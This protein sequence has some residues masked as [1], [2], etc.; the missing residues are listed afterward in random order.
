MSQAP[1]DMAQHPGLGIHIRMVPGKQVCRTLLKEEAVEVKGELCPL[2][3]PE[4]RKE[5]ALSLLHI[6]HS[7]QG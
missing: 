3:E 2:Q 7:G 6:A 4:S 1:R 5:P